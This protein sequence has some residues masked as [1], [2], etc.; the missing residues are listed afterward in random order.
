MGYRVQSREFQTA[1]GDPPLHT[2][3]GHPPS[4]RNLQPD[5]HSPQQAP[6]PG[7]QALDESAMARGALARHSPYAA[8]RIYLPPPVSPSPHSRM[9][10]LTQPPAG[11]SSCFS[12]HQRA[13]HQVLLGLPQ[14][15]SSGHSVPC[16]LISRAPRLPI[17][18]PFQE[19][20]PPPLYPHN[21]GRPGGWRLLGRSGTAPPPPGH[22]GVGPPPL[23]SRGWWNHV[24]KGGTW[25]REGPRWTWGLSPSLRQHSPFALLS[26]GLA[27]L[28]WTTSPESLGGGSKRGSPGTG[29]RLLGLWAAVLYPP[30]RLL[31]QVPA[32]CPPLR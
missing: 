18:L 31:S 3:R 5:H 27:L 20:C 4:W 11:P 2:P 15:T 25:L 14:G 13:L 23:R 1:V 8:P 19:A 7:P 29:G 12:W 17:Q 16:H 21:P 24:W 32:S 9:P 10:F 30:L 26:V 6:D 22:R 28:G